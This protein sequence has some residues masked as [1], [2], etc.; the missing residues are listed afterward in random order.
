MIKGIIS[1]ILTILTVITCTAQPAFYKHLEGKVGSNISIVL[2]MVVTG[3]KLGGY[4]YYYFDDKSGDDAWTHY[5]KSMPVNGQIN[6]LGEFDFSEFNTGVKGAHFKGSLKNGVI[7]AKWINDDGKKELPFT[8]KESYPAGTMA[9]RVIY[10]H[11]QAPLINKKASSPAAT[12]ELSLLLPA[13]YPVQSVA[14]SV[15][16]FIY[17]DFFEK[18]TLENDPAVLLNDARNHYF[19]NYKSSNTDIY[20]EGAA[21]FD[22]KK[23]KE[24]RILHN[25]HDILSFECF[26]YGFTGGAH[27]LSVSKFRVIDLQDGHIVS[28]AEIFRPDYD[29][30]LRDI[31]NAAARKKYNLES[32]QSLVDAG[33]FS[34]SIDTGPNYYITKDGMGFYYN[35]YEVAPFALGPIDIFINY[36]QLKRIL[37]PE[38]PVFRL[39]SNE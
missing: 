14:D 23:I 29:N 7:T 31:L 15:T 19:T 17:D 25:E 4:Y 36:A 30:D 18:D 35:Q 16:A 39:I 28:L 9:F 32:G 34:E 21:S 22:W 33:F 24:I 20:T 8:A 38:S 5:G 13:N 37:N 2:D 26:S 6:A 12:I 10:M 3:E 11:D 27:G 1:F